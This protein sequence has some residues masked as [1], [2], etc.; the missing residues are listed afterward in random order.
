MKNNKSICIIDDDAIY[1][2]ALKFL[3]DIS[4]TYQSIIVYENGKQAFE[5]FEQQIQQGISLPDT[6]LLDINM[7]MWDGWRFLEALEKIYTDK[8][9]HLYVMTS[10][11]NSYDY[12]K[13]SSFSMVKGCFEKPLKAADIQQI[14]ESLN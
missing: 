4:N 11:V 9:M 13:A 14:T 7:P 12:N 6:V 10:S 8:N 3:I 2:Y 1:V 5:A